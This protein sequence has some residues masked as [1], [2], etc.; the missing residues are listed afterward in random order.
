MD[1]YRFALLRSQPES[2][3][4]AP[5]RCGAVKHA[6]CAR[7][8]ERKPW[9]N[10]CVCRFQPKDFSPKHRSSCGRWTSCARASFLAG[11]AHYPKFIEE[12]ISHAL[13]AAARALTLLSQGTMHL[14]GRRRRSRSGEMRRLSDLHARLPIRHSHRCCSCQAGRV[15]AIWAAPLSSIRPNARAVA[16]V[17]AIVRQMPSNLS[18]TRMNK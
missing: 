6:H 7:H 3:A 17:P 8:R 9:Q 1:R 10:C 2:L 18:I 12:S 15:L 16:P 5:G 13:A 4:Y 14:G 11:M